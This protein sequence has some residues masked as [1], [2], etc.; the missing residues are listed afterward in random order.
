MPSVVTTKANTSYNKQEDSQ[1]LVGN[2][3]EER[4]LKDNTGVNRYQVRIPTWPCFWVA[5]PLPTQRA[6]LS[7]MGGGRSTRALCHAPE[8]ER[9]ANADPA[10]GHGTH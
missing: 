6:I 5:R 10:E 3:Y 9:R 8:C 2:W 1:T 4:C 7:D